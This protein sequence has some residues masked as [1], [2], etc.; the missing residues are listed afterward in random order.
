M[1]TKNMSA[2]LL[3]KLLLVLIVLILAV[4]IGIYYFLFGFVKSQADTAAESV[5][6]AESSQKDLDDLN[7]SY[8]WL[9]ANPETVDKTSKIVAQASSY[10]YQDQVIND[11]ESYAN[12]SGLNVISYRF[13]E[14]SGTGAA[15]S[16]SSAAPAS[17]SAAPSAAAGAA[18]PATAAAPSGLTQASID[19]GLDTGISYR[20]LLQFIKRIEQSVTRL[21]IN[22]IDISSVSGAENKKGVPDPVSVSTFTIS[23]FLNKGV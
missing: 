17:S 9:Q 12:Q 7:K 10:Q 1:N 21:Q 20:K 5:A 14:L 16:S 3:E 8:K 13:S 23:V 4:T 18:T 15:A 19:I 11:I 6:K 22:S 2:A